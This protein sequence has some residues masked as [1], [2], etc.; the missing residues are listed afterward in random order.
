M[1]MLKLSRWLQTYD[2]HKYY[3]VKYLY[4]NHKFD[5]KTYNSLTLDPFRQ[6]HSLLFSQDLA[7]SIM[8]QPIVMQ[9][10]ITVSD[11]RNSVSDLSCY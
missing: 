9:T 10:T 2:I 5:E 8:G 1:Q 4:Y 3:C 11:I 6:K 7:R